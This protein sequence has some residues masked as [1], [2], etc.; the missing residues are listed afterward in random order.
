MYE[1]DMPSG[2]S[3]VGVNELRRRLIEINPKVYQGAIPREFHTTNMTLCDTTVLILKM[4]N[5]Y[6]HS[7]TTRPPKCHEESG[8]EYHFISRK[9]FDTMVCNHRWSKYTSVCLTQSVV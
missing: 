6:F 4:S 7:D 8:R 1:Y 9:Q 3:G 5:F 2:P